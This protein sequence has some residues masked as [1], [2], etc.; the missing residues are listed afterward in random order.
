MLPARAWARAQGPEPVQVP[1]LRAPGLRAPGLAAVSLVRKAAS[2]RWPGPGPPS[3]RAGASIA[4]EPSEQLPPALLL[5]LLLLSWSFSACA[6]AQPFLPPPAQPP[7]GRALPPQQ[8]PLRS[9]PVLPSPPLSCA[10]CAWLWAPWAP[11]RRANPVALSHHCSPPPQSCGPS[12]FSRPHRR[13]SWW[14]FSWAPLLRGA[15]LLFL[16]CRL[17]RL[18][19]A[20]LAKGTASAVDSQKDV[21]RNLRMGVDV[22]DIVVVLQRIAQSQELGRKLGF[23]NSYVVIRKIRQL[24]R[25]GL[26]ARPF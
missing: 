2:H 11:P 12:I 8:E 22:L 19:R 13:L 18:L 24:H 5:P 17:E 25:V 21:V 26:N 20:P 6:S 23:V 15:L 7:P 16:A 10:S 3:R 1:V 4:W 14:S 9:V